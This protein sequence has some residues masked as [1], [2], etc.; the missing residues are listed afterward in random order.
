MDTRPHSLTVPSDDD[1][2]TFIRS[3]LYEERETAGAGIAV[4]ATAFIP[5][6][7]RIFCE[8][9]LIQV[10][11]EFE[12]PEIYD[13]VTSLS[14]E[15]Q[16]AYFG[17]AASSKSMKDVGWINDLRKSCEGEAESFNA[18]VEAHEMAWSIYETNRF[19]LRL[20]SGE[21]KI[22]IYHKAS[23]LNHSCAPN[24]FHR[25]NSRI[26]RM[27]IHALRDIQPGDE[28]N[29]SYIDICHPTAVRRQMLKGWGFH[30][31]C[32]AC[33]SSDEMRDLRRKKI[34]DVMN[35]LKKREEQWESN[36]EQWTDKDYAKSVSMIERGMRLMESEGMEETDTLGYLLALAI[37]YGARNGR[38]EEL[39]QWTERLVVIERKCL[40]E[41]SNEYD[42][43]VELHRIAKEDL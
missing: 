2:P 25:Y 4:F 16:A 5:A 32:S 9:E 42:A 27:T 6:G 18:L 41:D 11:D 1:S 15:K 14:E 8:E 17:L 36:H 37:R 3:E 29:T 19:T 34:E 31:G 13:T 22:G 38:K 23:R 28:L 26:N 20:S 43:A 12:Q 39:M 7:T 21:F 33:E 24:V 40:G 10:S 35:K 30:C